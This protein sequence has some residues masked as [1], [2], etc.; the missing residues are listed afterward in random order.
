MPARSGTRHATSS[1]KEGSLAY[2]SGSVGGWCFRSKHDVAGYPPWLNEGFEIRWKLR[3][4]WETM[5]QGKVTI[6]GIRPE[7]LGLMIDPT[8][9]DLFELGDPGVTHVP[10]E[11]RHPFFDLRLATFLLGLPRL[12]WCC[13]KELLREAARGILPDSVRLRRKSPMIAEPLV[14]VLGRPESAWVDRF[15]PLPE[16]QEYVIRSRIPAVYGE[17]DSWTGWVHLRPLSLNFWLRQAKVLS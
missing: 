6:T 3:D 2:I 12:P 8:W 17:K 16:L 14:A 1:R 4:R 10:V 5:S 11:V 13:D 15:E 9:I 7:A